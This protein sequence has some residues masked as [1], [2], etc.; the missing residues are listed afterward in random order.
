ME[1]YYYQAD[2][3]S[4]IQTEFVNGNKRVILCIPTGGGKTVTFADMARKAI[5]KGKRI[6]IA[7]DREKLLSQAAKTLMKYGLNPSII[8][9]GRSVRMGQNCYVATVQTL[10]KR[11]FPE[12]DLL[13]ID[14]AHKQIFDK[15]LRRPEYQDVFVIGATATPKRSGKM[16]QLSEFYQSMVEPTTISRLIS[17]GFLVPAITFG[18]KVDT[19]KI[20]TKG[21]DFDATALGNFFDKATMYGGM[22]DKYKKYAAGT[23]FVCFDV[24]RHNGAKSCEAFNKAGFPTAYIDGDTSERERNLI[25]DAFAKGL[26]IGLCNVDLLTA[27]FDEWTVETV[28]VN[29]ATKSLPKWLQMAGRGSRITPFVFVDKPGY[30]QKSHFNL[31]DMGGNVFT[32]GFWEAER[33]Y[34]LTH[35][36]KDALD[37]AP[38][39]IC[40]E[41]A[42]DVNDKYGCGAL[43]HLSIRVCK[44]C[45]WVFPETEKE[46]PKDVEFTQ[47]HYD[48]FLPEGVASKSIEEMNVAELEE[49]RESRGYKVGWVV[50]QILLNPDLDLSEY[51]QL[52]GYKNAAAWVAQT[53]DRYPGVK[54]VWHYYFRAPSEVWKQLEPLQDNAGV[55]QLSAEEF[56]RAVLHFKIET[57]TIK[58]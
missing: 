11:T 52:K 18:A 50:R 23:K 27:G 1:L 38:V 41:Y 42:A 34:S 12:I 19:S 8:K 28:I 17:E 7:V 47:L 21:E 13:I 15:I 5:L 25:Y 22:I 20:K 37:A 10:L 4:G 39:K 9:G 3:Q 49:F 36:T 14:E 57:E 56:A 43:A 35:K 45:G 26:Y 51:A 55:R 2:A 6:M 32:H 30:L 44:S 24:N 48:G 53:E 40:D 29:L 16:N 58:T 31:I 54:R 33:K 46:A